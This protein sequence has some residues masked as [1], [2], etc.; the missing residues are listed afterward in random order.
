MSFNMLS[1]LNKWTLKNKNKT[2]CDK[3]CVLDKKVK[4]NNN[5]TKNQTESTESNECRNDNKQIKAKFAGH[6]LSKNY[7]SV[8]F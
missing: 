6:T 5:K 2:F 3:Y 4:H 1:I 8:I 7:F